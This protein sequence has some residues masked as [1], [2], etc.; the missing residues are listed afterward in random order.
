M[1]LAMNE[2]NRNTLA[3]N[4]DFDDDVEQPL[5]GG[6]LR[7]SARSRRPNPSLAALSLIC[8]SVLFV[9]SLMVLYIARHN[10]PLQQQCVK[11]TSTYCNNP[12]SCLYKLSD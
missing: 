12:L 8:S 4:D 6:R 7:S 2:K 11:Q 3:V 1:S 9:A 10:G 5:T